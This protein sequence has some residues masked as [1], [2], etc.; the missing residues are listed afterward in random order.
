MCAVV[1]PLP[2][3]VGEAF[4]CVGPGAAQTVDQ[5]IDLTMKVPASGEF[6]WWVNPSTRPFVQKKGGRETYKLACEESGRTI[7]TQEVFVRRGDMAAVELPCGAKLPKFAVRL[8]ALK[9]VKRT[10]RTRAEVRGGSLKAVA[11]TLLDR[12][13]RTLGSARLASLTK[14]RKVTLKL[15]SGARVKRG[16]YR[17]RVTGT[18][19]DGS[20]YRATRTVAL[21]R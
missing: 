12:R 19:F 21:K 6:V 4:Y 8:G 10:A 7:S 11:F 20:R 17:V 2:V 3:D 13:G 14:A 18:R 1:S 16:R 9:L 5:R 15:R